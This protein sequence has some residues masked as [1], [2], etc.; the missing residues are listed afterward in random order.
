MEAKR[1]SG[2]KRERVIT[3]FPAYNALARE[4]KKGL[5]ETQRTG[6]HPACPASASNPFS[7]SPSLYL[8]ARPFVD[9]TPLFVDAAFFAD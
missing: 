7:L 4:I 1:K 8:L 2:E 5:A 9:D 6:Q 3:S